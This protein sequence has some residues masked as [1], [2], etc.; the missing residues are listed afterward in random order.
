MIVRKKIF[1]FLIL[2]LLANCSFDS[3]TGIWK[4]DKKEKE[5]ISELEKKQK[6]I[7]DTY[8]VYSSNNE[9]SKEIQLSKK[10]VMPKP[11]KN[12]IWE[13]SGLNRQNFLGNIYST[14]VENKF[15]K[16]KI[17]SNKF[18]INI[19]TSLLASENNIFF[20]DD[21]G[22]LFNISEDGKINWKQNIYSKAYKKIYKNLRFSIFGNT[23][24]VS[25]NVGFVYAINIDNGNLIWTKNY[26][27]S[28]RS[29]IKI[30]DNKIFLIDQ[31][32]KI[33]CLDAKD[34]SMIWNVLSISSFIK[35]RN[36]LSV[37]LS[38]DGDLIAVNSSGDLFNINSL[39][40]NI[41]WATNTSGSLYAGASDFFKS[42]DL[43]LTDEEIIFSTGKS[44]FSY[45]IN[46]AHI[47]WQNNVSSVGAPIIADNNIFIVTENGYF[48]IIKK[49][50]G[51]IISSSNVLRI[52][53]RKKQETKITGFIM[54]SG[55]IY[56]VTLN[57]YLI[58]SSAT[59]GKV[60][61]FK[62]IGEPITMPPIIVNGKLY[63]LTENSR[64]LGFN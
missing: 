36:L 46:D 9:Y 38:M 54:G 37:A 49:D 55:M 57:G 63:I 23:I 50:T 30:L 27:V 24:Y 18:D 17:G 10:V 22:T 42:S 39:D 16:K 48:L 56:S 15:L 19:K 31:D 60:E 1:F 52:L 28:L 26:G 2:V 61:F 29:N 11:N 35:S 32:N 64:I 12:F 51:K 34:G 47:N 44:I 21:K 41:N 40:G 43:V 4:G 14:G 7:I 53:K 13:M 25:D 3:K 8:K 45:N 33:I 5:K 20:S 6:N 62:K 59:S 58:A